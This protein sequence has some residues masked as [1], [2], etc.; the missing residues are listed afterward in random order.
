[1]PLLS[2]SIAFLCG[3][4]L[5]AGIHFLLHFLRNKRNS[6]QNHLH[7][8]FSIMCFLVVGYMVAELVAY[9]AQSGMEYVQA[10]KWRAGFILLYAAVWPWFVYHYFESGSRRI[11]LG[12]SLLAF[13]QLI[14]VIFRPYG[15]FFEELPALATTT[16]PWGEQ[17]V[18]H[19]DSKMNFYSSL[20]WMGFIAL[21]VYTFYVCY[22]QYHRGQHQKAVLLASA[23]SVCS[24]F[25]LVNLL[26]RAGVIDFIFLAQ[27]GFPSLVIIMG[28]A[29]QHDARVR[30]EH[31]FKKDRETQARYR[32]LVESTA[33]IAWELDLATWCFTYVGPQVEDLLGYP[34]EQWYEKEFWAKHIHPEDCDEALNFCR[35][36]TARGEDH[37][38]EYRMLAATGREVWLQDYVRVIS[39]KGKPVRL[40]GYMF[41]ITEHK[42]EQKKIK[43]NEVKFRTLF[44]TAGDAIFL[45]HE[46]KFVDCNPKTLEIFGC[47]RDDIVGNTPMAFS[48]PVQYDGRDSVDKALDKI[49]SAL[50]GEPQFF[51]WLHCRLDGS[52]FD[53]EV[54]LNRIELDGTSCIQAIVRDVSARRRSEE[55]LRNI[56][57][58]VTGQSGEI[59]Y[60]QMVQS[61]GNLLAAKYAFIGLLD[62][63]DRMQVNTLSVSVDGVIADNM[64]YRLEKTPCENV[65]GHHTC[66]YA[67][68][69]QELFP[70]DKLLQDMGVDSYIGAPLFNIQ[71]DPIGLVVILDTKP[72][73]NLEQVKP[74][75]EIFAARA[76]AELERMKAETHI[77]RMAFEDYLTGLNNR[78]DLHEHMKE[79]LYRIKKNNL[80]GAMLL[81][82]LDHFKTINDALSHDVGDQVLKLVGQRLSDISAESTYLARIGGDEFVAL[83][84]SDKGE[85][86]DAFEK[87]ARNYADKIVTELSESLHLDNR[88]LSIGASV[89]VIVFPQ[90]GD[91]E[92]DIMRRADMALYCAKNRGRGNVQ[93]YEPSLQENVDERLQIERG[94]RH[95]IDKEEL[96]LHYQPQFNIHGEVIGAE[97]LLRWSHPELGQVPPDQFI[98]VAEE[99]GLIHS[100]G[101]WVINEACQQLHQWQKQT[102]SFSGHIA[103]NVSAWQFANPN[104]VSQ[105]ISAMADNHIDSHQIALELTET[106]LLYDLQETIDKLAKLRAIGIQ[107]ALDDFGTGYSSLAYLKDMAMD[108]LKIDKAFIHEL[109]TTNAHPL[110]ETIIAMGQ[111]MGLEV[112]AEGVE[113]AAQSDILVKLGCQAFQGFFFARPMP[114]A[115]F[116][117]WLQQQPGIEKQKNQA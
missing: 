86:S 29:M 41:D 84:T 72:M 8:I 102:L 34:A 39:E 2:L 76:S 68:N 63:D 79:V 17:L 10:F 4:C 78:A 44:E 43:Q 42:Q 60:Q 50:N 53:A 100:I 96:T 65:V 97:A 19:A 24:A 116:I 1:M 91:T 106:A 80:S 71:N 107:I 25:I 92:L 28:L 49:T 67:T 83:L 58:G 30:A 57:A 62:D 31:A 32:S 108:V 85:P 51:D 36:A 38:F 6:S 59:F 117:I 74:I 46:D 66:T 111:H 15:E 7:L 94:L 89:G 52:L 5:Y 14:P 95:A 69:V 101:E 77:R 109:S 87:N 22:K 70:D 105:V 103:I 37:E 13:L 81:I 98:P 90:Q 23:L 3:T 110:V 35:T 12:F 61:L 33:A 20:M 56:A 64:S 114:A 55:A 40:Q 45:M 27:F 26:V 54:S 11:A 104:F 16:L 73:T 113:T 9:Q 99:T 75:L 47:A 115:D 48:P 93:F 82:D 21:L 88:I 18:F 112:V